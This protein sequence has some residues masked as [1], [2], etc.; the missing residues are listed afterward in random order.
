[1][2]SGDRT[3]DP[4]TSTLKQVG[5]K[6]TQQRLGSRRSSQGS[7]K[8]LSSY[9]KARKSVLAAAGRNQIFV[10]EA[11][12]N[13]PPQRIDFHKVDTKEDCGSVDR[14]SSFSK[15]NQPHETQMFDASYYTQKKD[16]SKFKMNSEEGHPYA[17]TDHKLRMQTEG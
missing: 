5:R 6:L 17:L 11:R 7:Q 10:D 1:M 9:S 16:N 14:Q 15:Q 4:C 8:N 13:T 2:S 12:P 3:I